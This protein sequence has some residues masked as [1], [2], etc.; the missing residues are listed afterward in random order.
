MPTNNSVLKTYYCSLPPL[1]LLPSL[2]SLQT[3]SGSVWRV[4]WAHPEFGQVLATCSFDRTVGVW[5]EQGELRPHEVIF[6][7][8]KYILQLS[9][10][11]HCGAFMSVLLLVSL[12]IGILGL[13]CP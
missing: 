10:Q 3:H 5:E 2:P 13:R 6:S 1:P 12:C 4:N 9:C 8:L 11:Y 7:K